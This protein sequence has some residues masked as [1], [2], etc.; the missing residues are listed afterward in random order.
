MGVWWTDLTRIIC[1]SFY[2]IRIC[3]LAH[4]QRANFRYSFHCDTPSIFF[5]LL[6]IINRIIVVNKRTFVFI[7]TLVYFAYIVYT[8]CYIQPVFIA[9]GEQLHRCD[10]R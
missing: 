4:N 10:R 1:N 3:E 5:F 2:N 7:F 8:L 6:P 9:S